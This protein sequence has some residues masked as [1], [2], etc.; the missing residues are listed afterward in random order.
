MQFGS[1][2]ITAGPA[3]GS[4]LVTA[5]GMVV[6]S[7]MRYGMNPNI[8][9]HP[10]ILRAA[11]FEAARNP[12]EQAKKMVEAIVNLQHQANVLEGFMGMIEFA[13]RLGSNVI[14]GPFQPDLIPVIV[15]FDI[16][17]LGATSNGQVSQTIDADAY[18]Q[19]WVAAQFDPTAGLYVFNPT[20]WNIRRGE[21]FFFVSEHDTSVSALIGVGDEGFGDNIDNIIAWPSPQYF[22]HAD[23]LTLQARNEGANATYKYQGAAFFAV[24]A[25]QEEDYNSIRWN[26]DPLVKVFRSGAF[27]GGGPTKVATFREPVR[28]FAIRANAESTAGSNTLTPVRF[29]MRNSRR[30]GVMDGYVADHLLTGVNNQRTLVLSTPLYLPANGSLAVQWNNDIPTTP[31]A[32]SHNVSVIYQQARRNIY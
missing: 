11:L 30:Y 3:S 13:L 2:P 31:G 27:T 26:A 14:P 32:L 23:Q 21:N 7:P 22:Q 4:G 25:P 18:F 16:G 28:I 15:P 10:P 1:Q 5:P 29:Q 17:V 12:G 8:P 19:G 20:R 9:R 6:N 24:R